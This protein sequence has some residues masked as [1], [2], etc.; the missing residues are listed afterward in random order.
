[1]IMFRTT[2][3]DRVAFQA[4]EMYNARG[5]VTVR[6]VIDRSPGYHTPTRN[7]VRMILRTLGY[8]SE[9]GRFIK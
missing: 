3:R 5:Y 6:G 7:E 2:K 1:M 9:D 8:K 4:N